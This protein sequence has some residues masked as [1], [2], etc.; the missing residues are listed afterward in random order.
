[1]WLVR[2]HSVSVSR[3]RCSS[4]SAHFSQ[5]LSCGYS[6][7]A[8]TQRSP[9]EYDYSFVTQVA[10]IIVKSRTQLRSRR[11]T[12]L[13]PLRPFFI[14]PYFL[15]FFFPLF[16]LSLPFLS[17]AFSFTH[18]L[19]SPH[20]CHFSIYLFLRLFPFHFLSGPYCTSALTN[21][22]NIPFID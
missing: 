8:A 22:R 12:R 7:A 1:V 18:F 21:R 13:G 6:Q 10:A 15:I 19:C 20:F 16:S 11:W 17:V 9:A 5:L 4:L 2:A 14:R 3:L